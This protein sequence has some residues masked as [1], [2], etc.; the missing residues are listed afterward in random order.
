MPELS[1]LVADRRTVAV[2][3]E[4]AALTV[5]YRPSAFTVEFEAMLTNPPDGVPRVELYL[6]ALEQLLVEWDLTRNGKP[7]PI[8]VDALRQLPSRLLARV[9]TAIAQDHAAGEAG[10]NSPG[11]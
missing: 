8:K 5:T 11:G 9:I 3:G 10:D 7:V 6:K 1:D 2:P 4:R